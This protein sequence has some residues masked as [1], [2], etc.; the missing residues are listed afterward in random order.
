MPTNITVPEKLLRLLTYHEN[1]AA[2]IRATIALM[3]H[4]NGTAVLDKRKEMH[5]ANG[6]STIARAA[7]QM[8]DARREQKRAWQAKYIA[9]KKAGKVTHPN[10]RLNQRQRTADTLAHFDLTEPKLPGELPYQPQG[11][12]RLVVNGYLKRK[13]PG[14]VRTAK[15]YYVN[16]K[17]AAATP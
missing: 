2:N 4:L 11:L 13:G 9:R 1:A 17:K 16:P 6:T 8:D 7:L 15:P 12:G 14:Y 10:S 3:Q 5:A